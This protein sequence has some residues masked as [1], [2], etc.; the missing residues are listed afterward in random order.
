MPFCRL[1]DTFSP[2]A[3]ARFV[4]FPTT[5]NP[6]L[7]LLRLSPWATLYRPWRAYIPIG[8]GLLPS[9]SKIVMPG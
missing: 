8:E 2:A 5:T 1:F 9:P 4:G 7:T 3:A 6:G